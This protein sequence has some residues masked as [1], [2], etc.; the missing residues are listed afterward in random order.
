MAQILSPVCTDLLKFQNSALSSR[1][2]A[3]PRFSAKTTGASSS[4]YLPRYAGKR[5]TDSIGRLRVATEDASSLSTGDV[6]DDYYAV[7][8]LLPDATQEEIK[9]AYYNCMKSCHPDLSGNDPETTNFCMFINDIYEIL[10]DPVQRMVYDEIH[11][12][13][14]TAI[15]PFLD[16]STPRDHVF[17]DEFACIGCKNCANVAPDIFQIEEDFGRARACNQR[18]NPDLVQQAVE[19]CPVDCIHQTS[20]AQLSLLEDE[21]RRVE[22]VNVALML[23]GMGSGAVDVFR[24]ARSRWEKRQAKVLNQARSR[25]MKRKNTDETPSYWDNLWGKQ[26]EYQKSEEEVQE[27]AQRAAAAARRWREYSRRGVDKRPTFKLPD[28]ASRGDN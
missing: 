14:V 15:N 20:A 10:S 25:M 27:R 4:W 23:S 11:G 3:S 5:R 18:G 19:T 17:V 22:R 24:M 1:S 8:G 16:D 12:Y 21:M 6:A 2:G 7:L 28:S 26:N 9:K 13:T